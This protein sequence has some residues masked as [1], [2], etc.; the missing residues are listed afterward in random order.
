[1]IGH[2]IIY[3]SIYNGKY[4][5]NIMIGNRNIYKSIHRLMTWGYKDFNMGI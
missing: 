1:M 2:G 5:G 3:K 4:N